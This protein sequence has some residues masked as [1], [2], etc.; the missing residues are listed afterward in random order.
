MTRR[1]PPSPLTAAC[2]LAGSALILLA[3]DHTAR[4]CG[5]FFCQSVPV[6]QTGEQIIFRKD[7]DRITAIVRIQ[8]TGPSEVFSWVVPVPGIPEFEVSSDLLFPTLEL[9]TRP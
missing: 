9:A 8:Y 3:T 5:G 1:I 6:T 2:L 7:G 4:A